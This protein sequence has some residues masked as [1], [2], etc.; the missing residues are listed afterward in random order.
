VWQNDIPPVHL[1]WFSEKS[2]EALAKSFGKKC[3]FI[4][5]TP[6]TKKYFEY[7]VSVPLAEIESNLPRLTKDGAIFPGREVVNTKAKFF[8]VLMY[9]RISNILRQLKPKTVSTRSSSMCAV[10]S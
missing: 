8:S 6:Y 4:D 3:S 5:F 10:I 1:W 2:I 9:T 7:S